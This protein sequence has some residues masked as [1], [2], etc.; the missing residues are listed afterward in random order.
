MSPYIMV[1]SLNT[2]DGICQEASQMFKEYL[3]KKATYHIANTY[4]LFVN[5]VKKIIGVKTTASG[6]ST[7][8][9]VCVFQTMKIHVLTN[10]VNYKT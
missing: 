8:H 3:H 4:G 7:C 1:H 2:L 5:I 6:V 10:W 9:N